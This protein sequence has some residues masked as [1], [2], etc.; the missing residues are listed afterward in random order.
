MHRGGLA[1]VVEVARCL[2]RG[3]GRTVVATFNLPE[4]REGLFEASCC[5]ELSEAGGRD[6]VFP[7]E[8]EAEVAVAREAE[9]EGDIHEI[10]LGRVHSPEGL[11]EAKAV[12]VAVDGEVRLRLEDAAEVAGGD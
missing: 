7:P 12:Q 4:F 11:P 2:P 6:A 1:I 5:D 9:V 10:R 3:I 8:G